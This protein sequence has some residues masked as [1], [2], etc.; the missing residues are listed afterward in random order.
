MNTNQKIIL[1]SIILVIS[2]M[3]LYPPFNLIAKN[4]TV[5]NMGYAWIFEPPRRGYLVANV[6]TAM[7]LIQW[8]GVIVVGGLIFVIA[9]SPSKRSESSSIAFEQSGNDYQGRKTETYTFDPQS[10][11]EPTNRRQE[12]GP[13]PWGTVFLWTGLIFIAVFFWIRPPPESSDKAAIVFKFFFALPSAL[14]G[15]VIIGILKFF[16]R[17][18]IQPDINQIR[19]Q[20]KHSAQQEH[21]QKTNQEE[22][23]TVKCPLC[24]NT[25]LKSEGSYYKD[26]KGVKICDSCFQ[27][28]NKDTKMASCA[29]CGRQTPEDDLLNY[30]AVKICPECH[31]YKN[32]H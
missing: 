1:I 2:G 28:K 6:N 32:A 4:G 22:K 25:M 26:F 29:L 24:N 31:V 30:M 7:L 21:Q 23:L 12:K 17:P 8:I 27:K 19:E 9:K 16:W 14:L 10:I 3:F 13:Y 18:K 11:D 20:Q 15:G 5:L